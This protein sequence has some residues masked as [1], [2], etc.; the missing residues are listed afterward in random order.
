[1]TSY[2]NLNRLNGTSNA[3]GKKKR[4]IFDLDFDLKLKTEELLIGD[5]LLIVGEETRSQTKADFEYL[6]IDVV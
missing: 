3:H 4:E 5:L 6:L 2:L 1:M